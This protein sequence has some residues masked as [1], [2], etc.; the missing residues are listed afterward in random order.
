MSKAKARAK[1]AAEKFPKIILFYGHRN[2]EY[3]E[4]SQWNQTAPFTLKLDNDNGHKKKGSQIRFNNCEQYM[5]YR[6]A[7]L[8]CDWNTANQILACR[9]PKLVKAFGRKIKNFDQEVWDEEKFKI[10]V[11]GNYLRFSQN[12]RIKALLLA[13]GDSLIAEASPIDAIWGIGISETHLD[14]KCP[15]KW[16]DHGQNLSGKAL[17]EVRYRLCKEIDP[18]NVKIKRVIYPGLND[19]E[20]QDQITSTI[21]EIK[22]Q[23]VIN[24]LSHTYNV[25]PDDI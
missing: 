9:N 7:V 3:P 20:D 4:F 11:E 13:T 15:D 21:Q 5:M 2:G 17:M 8:F 24:K 25:N 12:D 6:K 14:A 10:V 23:A 16:S 1:Q 19:P 22:R 18:T